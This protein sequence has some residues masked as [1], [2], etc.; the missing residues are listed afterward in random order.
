M[1]KPSRWSA[2]RRA[3]VLADRRRERARMLAEAIFS[4]KETNPNINIKVS[5]D[6]LIEIIQSAIAR[7]ETEAVEEFL[8]EAS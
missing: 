2:S 8:S 3:K 1:A 4:A 6:D 7:G 5:K